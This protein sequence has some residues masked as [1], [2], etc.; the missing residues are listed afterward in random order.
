MP[1]AAKP[2]PGS[3]EPA[4]PAQSVLDQSEW[5]RVTLARMGDAVITRDPAGRV[6]FLNPVAQSVTGWRLEEAAGAPLDSVFEIVNEGTRRTVENPATRALREGLVVGLAND[7]MLIAKDGTE[8]PIDDSAAP[9]RNAQGDIAGV[10]LVFRDV[11]ERRRKERAVQNTLDYVQGIVETIRESLIVL[12]KNLRVMTANRSF[13][14]TFH[15]AP[16]N[17]ENRL[18]YEL[19]NHDWDIP[20]LRALLEDILP[21]NHSFHDFEVE[22]VFPTIGRKT[23][24]LTA[25]RVRRGNDPTALILLAFGHVT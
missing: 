3:P 23:M 2:N 11:T 9:I 17:T 18:V 22:H 12:D 4:Q 8:R 5:L 19:G 16:E 13:Y 10:V 24:L 21:S 15:V 6:T 14:K 1:M 20:K 7:T 25:R